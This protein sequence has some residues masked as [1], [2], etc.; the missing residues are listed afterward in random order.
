MAV[1]RICSVA[2]LPPAAR[3]RAIREIW[4]WERLEYGAGQSRALGA[5]KGRLGRYDEG[6]LCALARGRLLGYADV[7]PLAPSHYE[8]LRGG[9]ILEERMP[10]RWLGGRRS[11]RSCWYIG[12]LVV[13]RRLRVGHPQRAHEL[14]RRLQREIWSFITERSRLPV[15]VLGISATS[16]GQAKFRQT[17]FRAISTRADAADPRPR[18]ECTFS[19]RAQLLQRC[20]P[21]PPSLVRLTAVQA[22]RAATTGPA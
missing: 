12:S 8:Q 10:S 21:V 1:P 14:S 3:R 22:A 4:R 9:Q 11:R 20:G 7:M 6:V 15:R 18:F 17:G 2:S 13:S 5:I 16:V 19:R